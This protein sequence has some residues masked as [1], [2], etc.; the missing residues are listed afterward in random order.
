MADKKERTFISYVDD[1]GQ[2]VSGY[3][4]VIEIKDGF[5]AFDTDKNIIR[6][7][8]HRVLKMKEAKKDEQNSIS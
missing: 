1:D 8:T 6:I 4:K 7:P 5:V 3:F 2:T